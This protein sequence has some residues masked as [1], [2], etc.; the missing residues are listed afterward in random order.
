MKFYIILALLFTTFIAEAKPQ[1][2]I[3]HE[4]VN[5]EY[6]IYVD[7]D[8][9]CHVSVKIDFKLNNMEVDGGN[10]QVYVIDPRS[11]RQQLTKITISNT[12]LA[13]NFNY[14]YLRSYGNHHKDEYDEDYS[15]NLPFKTSNEFRVNQGYNGTF[16]HQNQNALDIIMPIGTKI[17]A[18]REGIV[19]EVVEKNSK[20]C[21]QE[22]CKKY[23]NKIII[24]HPDGTFAEYT[25]IKQNGSVVEVG[26]EISKG[27]HIGF[28]GNVGWSSGP[29]LHL[30]VFKQKL[31][32]RET[33]ET[34]F[35]T[36]DG[37]QKEYLLEKEAYSRG[38]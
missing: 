16:S 25:H 33:L 12:R 38:Y 29:H 13:Y 17:M 9:F 27:Q 18:I 28:S 36:G 8:E 5:D 20:N 14:R 10:L 23:N 6:I 1:I 32:A 34:K 11:K 15:Y 4:Q 3:Y 19:T 24:Y 35:R 22:E 7:S 2:K 31:F 21:A 26:D 37:T 30:V